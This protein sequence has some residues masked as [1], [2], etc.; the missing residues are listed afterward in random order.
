MVTADVAAGV[1]AGAASAAPAVP[2][3]A[4][5]AKRPVAAAPASRRR[6]RVEAVIGHTFLVSER[7][8]EPCEEK[9]AKT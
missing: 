8:P 6:T 5:P 3:A 4:P 2:R 7:T 9:V 1:R